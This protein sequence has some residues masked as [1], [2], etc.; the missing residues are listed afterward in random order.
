MSKEI[1]GEET[2]ID[3][4]KSILKQRKQNRRKQP[5]IYKE[6]RYE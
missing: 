3:E 1:G 2:N 4:K 6:K 5:N